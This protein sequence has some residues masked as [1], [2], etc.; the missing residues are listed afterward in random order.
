[1]KTIIE[2]C[3]QEVQKRY[4]RFES[5]LLQRTGMKSSLLALAVQAR[6]VAQDLRDHPVVL[7]QATSSSEPLT[8]ERRDR[9]VMKKRP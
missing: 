4:C 7:S 1:M 2:S 3:H 9:G 5:T 8:L 6:Q